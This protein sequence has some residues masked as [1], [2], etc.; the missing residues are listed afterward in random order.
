MEESSNLASSL[1][2][3]SE[4]GSLQN[5]FS[6]S[7]EICKNLQLTITD[8]LHFRFVFP[9]SIQT[10]FAI[11]W[12]QVQTLASSSFSTN[13][14]DNRIFIFDLKKDLLKGDSILVSIKHLASEVKEHDEHSLLNPNPKFD[15]PFFD[16][17]INSVNALVFF[18]EYKNNKFTY[19]KI[20][21]AYQIQTGITAEELI[22]KSATD[23]DPELG[24]LVEKRFKKVLES[25]KP[26]D[27]L[28]SRNYNNEV[29]FWQSRLTPLFCNDGSQFLIGSAYE[30]SREQMYMQ[31][32]E[33][34]RHLLK[35]LMDYSQ[36]DIYFKD[37]DSRFIRINS[38]TAKKLGLKSPEDAIGKS[39]YDF[40]ERDIAERTHI[41][42]KQI[43]EKGISITSK[44]EMGVLQ[45]NSNEIIWGST[46]KFP[47][48]DN[49]GK[50]IGIIGITRDITEKKRTELA[51][52]DS[53]QKFRLLADN[54]IDL[55]TTSKPDGTITYISP[56]VSKLLDYPSETSLAKNFFQ[57]IHPKDL[58][59]LVL[60]TFTLLAQT[61][62]IATI[63]FRVKHNSGH[64]LWFSTHSKKI[65]NQKTGE[66]EILSVSRDITVEHELLEQLQ[67]T[68]KQKDKLFSVISHDLRSPV[69]AS[70]SLTKILLEGIDNYKRDEIIEFLNMILL[71]SEK[72]NSLMEELLTW[73]RTQL[74]K[75][76]VSIQDID[77]NKLIESSRYSLLSQLNQKNIELKITL[78]TDKL[79]KTD[80]Q[81]LST[82][83]RN[84]ISNAIKYSNK[85]SKIQVRLSY[86]DNEFKLDV[87]D[88]GTGMTHEQAEKLISGES[89][90]ST[91]GTAG[92]KGTGLGFQ[93][94]KDFAK[95]LNGRLEISTA[96]EMGTTISLFLPDRK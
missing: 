83:I 95:R 33:N 78:L 25:K 77:Y 38:A 32:L 58:E 39:D 44:D 35:M 3:F 71:S 76:T 63:E 70:L 53:E 60:P 85:G 69:S 90:E 73:S 46:S 93:I 17:I 41:D 50:V 67:E 52:M 24:A 8:K 18:I 28:I 89:F 14:I 82:I 80:F 34:E 13:G 81:L 37:S 47:M 43:L 56:S 45:Q 86:S 2:L 20:N 84:L 88:F 79:L 11:A 36:D 61:H 19:R 74:N 30:V 65:R 15:D 23:V 75:I 94:C 54:I 92:E 9:D 12:N 87:Q 4:D 51:L 55:V 66:I 49:S 31:A 68:N 6:K 59:E 91:Y 48:K 27:Y 62:E 26:L 5:I 22:G 10:K 40:F 29:K 42:E 96:K 57:L 1:L 16:F 72:L 21:L 7:D 64:Y